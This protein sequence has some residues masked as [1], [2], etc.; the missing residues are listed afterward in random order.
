[1]KTEVIVSTYN[2]P[3]FLGLTLLSLAAQKLRPGS[4]C[5]ADDGSGPETRAAIDDF[6]ARHPDLPVRH[7][8]HEDAGFRKNVILNRA[9]ATSAADHLIFT[10][11]DCLL[12]PGFVARHRTLVAPGRFACGSLIRLPKAATEAV[13]AA[14]VTAGRVF[15]RDWLRAAG[16]FDRVTTWLKAMPFPD[17]VQR[18]LDSIY[19]IRK[20]WMGSNASALREAIVAVNG[21]D[22]T[23]A[24]GGE[25]KEFG[26]RL[27][28]SGV[29]GRR[30][31]FTAPVVHLDHPR[32]YVDPDRVRENRARIAEV[33]RS[34]RHWTPDGLVKSPKSTVAAPS[35]GGTSA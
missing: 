10:D 12:S 2:A 29:A 27:A 11:G 9:V 18:G 28:N 26:I 6:A 15:D 4:V 25:D 14:D 30:L 35:A 32:G 16:A 34:G 7:V 19:P 24:W 23:M 3:R 33:R 1:M 21:F 20:T 13:S 17:P 5:I 31:R 8:W 22:E